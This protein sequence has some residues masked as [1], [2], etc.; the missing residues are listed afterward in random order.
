MEHMLADSNIICVTAASE[1]PNQMQT[2]EHSEKTLRKN[3]CQNQL[4][5]WTKGEMQP[6]VLIKPAEITT[7]RKHAKQS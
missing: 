2:I 4:T 5:L 3:S 1:D 6:M 7:D